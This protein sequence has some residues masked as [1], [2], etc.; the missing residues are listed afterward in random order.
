MSL[1]NQEWIAAD[2]AVT[3]LVQRHGAEAD[4]QA[5]CE[6][7]RECF[8]EMTAASTRLVADPDEEDRVWAVVEIALPASHPAELLHAQRVRYSEEVVKRVPFRR[9]PAFSLAIS[10]S[11]GAQ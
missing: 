6:A 5:F 8:P 4:F 11:P 9:T 1:T 7:V 3:E 10:F 2:R